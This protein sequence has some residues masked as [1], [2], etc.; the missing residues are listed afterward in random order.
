MDKLQIH[1]KKIKG[2]EDSFWYDGL[3]ASIGKYRLIASGDVRIDTKN[4]DCAYSGGK[5]RD[6]RLETLVRSDKTLEKHVGQN[7]TDPYYWDMNNWFEVVYAK[8][9]INGIPQIEAD[10]MGVVE[11]DYTRAINMLKAYAKEKTY[12]KK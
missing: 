6:S 9:I 1:Q 4:G 10:D 2:C 7:Y 12:S 8:E 3:I 11:Y 5:F